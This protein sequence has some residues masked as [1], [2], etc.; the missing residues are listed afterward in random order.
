M[1]RDS[2][3]HHLV[4]IGQLAREFDVLPSTI[5]FYTREGLLPENGRSRGGYRLY[6]K[7][8]ALRRLEQISQLQKARRLTIEEIKKLLKIR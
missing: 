1:K 6:D 7:N 4:K 8:Q 2:E 5:N 3:S